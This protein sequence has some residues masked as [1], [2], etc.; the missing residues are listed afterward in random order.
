[1]SIKSLNYPDNPSFKR[2]Q[3][4]PVQHERDMFLKNGEGIHVRPIRGEDEPAL[5]R[6]FEKLSV[7]TVFFRFG[8]PRINMTHE[9]LANLCQIDYDQDLAF[10]AFV[11]GEEETVIGEVRLNKLADPETAELSFIVADRWQGEGVGNLLMGFSME[12]ARE[13][14][15]KT[16]LLEVM[17]S[18]RRMKWFGCKYGF[19]P[20]PYNKEDDMVAMQL[21]IDDTTVDQSRQQPAIEKSGFIIPDQCAVETTLMAI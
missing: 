8:Q 11:Y 2:V 20:L 15:I 16:L 1:M 3:G 4:Y 7:D 19:Q 12:V 5:Q 18:N 6:F 14:G 21:I 10:L 17:K 9:H 13:V